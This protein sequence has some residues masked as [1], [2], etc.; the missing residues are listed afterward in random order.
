MK[1]GYTEFSYGYAFT[2]NLTR[3]LASAPTGAPVFPN[4][5]QEAKVGYDVNINL[6]AA[7]LFFQFKLPERMRKGT[8]FEVSNGG[9]PGLAIPF[10][11]IALMRADLSKQHSRLI[12]LETK[13]PGCVFYAAPVLSDIHAFNKSYG[14]GRVFNDSV[15]FSPGDIGPL[16]DN[17]QHTIAYRSGLA[18]AFFCSDP[19]EKQKWSFDDISTKIEAS[20]K[21]KQFKDA[22][23]AARTIRD[24]VINLAS[25]EWRRQSAGLADRIRIRIRAATTTA[26]VDAQQE[27]TVTDLLVAREIARVDLGLELV[28]A[29]PG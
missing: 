28:L 21:Q 14:L 9:C 7:P 24:E 19:Q 4:L 13:F 22:P 26:A 12:E 23:A 11:R 2:E 15:F 18:S 6:P 3:S 10:Y 29:Q 1:V 16:P 8:A 20:F 5:V 27:E 17:K 25:A